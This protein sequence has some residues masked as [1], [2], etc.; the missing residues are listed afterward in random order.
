MLILAAV[1]TH[2]SYYMYICAFHAAWVQ[3]RYNVTYSTSEKLCTDNRCVIASVLFGCF[4]G[5]SWISAQKNRSWDWSVKNFLK[6]LNTAT[7]F[8]SGEVNF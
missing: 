1:K 5:F 7:N 2:S 3:G 4:Q 6:K 8:D